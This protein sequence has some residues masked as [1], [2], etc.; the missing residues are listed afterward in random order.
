MSV[1]SDT[2]NLDFL[3]PGHFLI[4][5]PLV[6]LPEDTISKPTHSYYRELTIWTYCAPVL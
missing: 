1:D 2:F 5:Q 6:S 3:T 4:G